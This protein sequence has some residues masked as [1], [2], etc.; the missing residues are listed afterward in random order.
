MSS[1]RISSSKSDKER[2]EEPARPENFSSA[3]INEILR[4]NL[5]YDRNN[6]YKEGEA[7]REGMASA[8]GLTNQMQIE[9]EMMKRQKALDDKIGIIEYQIKQTAV[10]WNE[11]N[12]RHKQNKRP[13]E[14]KPTPAVGQKRG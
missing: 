2:S 7:N 9:E 1:P 14:K 3:K 8:M 5:G 4:E 6:T 11:W 13:A 12:Q 10:K